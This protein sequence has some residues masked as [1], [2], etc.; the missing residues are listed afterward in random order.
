MTGAEGM[1]PRLQIIAAA[2]IGAIVTLVV[3]FAAGWLGN[4][5]S[6]TVTCTF[7]HD[8]PEDAEACWCTLKMMFPKGDIIDE[9]L[10]DVYPGDTVEWTLTHDW[11]GDVASK[12]EIWV[13]VTASGHSSVEYPYYFIGIADLAMVSKIAYTMECHILTYEGESEATEWDIYCIH[14][15]VLEPFDPVQV[16]TLELSLHNEGEDYENFWVMAGESAVVTGMLRANSSLDLS[17]PI[18]RSFDY[19]T[20][21]CPVVVYSEPDVPDYDGILQ[22]EEDDHV[23]LSVTI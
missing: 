17:I 3:M 5:K 19:G 1:D 21:D 8:G 18:S 15:D 16:G 12:V 6:A 10:G 22:V 14:P 9:E 7:Y 23:A 13:R 20:Y 11:T 2:A 4:S